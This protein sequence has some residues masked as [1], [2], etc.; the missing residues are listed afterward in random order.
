MISVQEAKELVEQY[1]KKLHPIELPLSKTFGKIL[2]QDV[3]ANTD[4]PA[5]PQSAMDGYAIQ[6]DSIHLD[7][8][9]VVE[10]ESQ[11]GNTEHTSCKAGTAIRIF[12][13]APIPD[14]ADT[15]VIQ[16]HV[17]ASQGK[18][19]IEN[20]EITKGQNIRPQG[21]QVKQGDVA[22]FAGTR[23]NAGTIGFLAG[24]GI[25]A[26]K[27]YPEPKIAL[28]VTGKE[29]VEAGKPLLHGQIYESNSIMLEAALYGKH[30]QLIAK[31]QAD[32]LEEEITEKIAALLPACDILLLTGGVSV[33]DYD[34]V[35]QSL[36]ANE[37]EKVFYKVKQKPGKPLFFGI[38]GQ[39]LV[40]GLPGNPGSV[41]S[42]FYEYVVPAIRKMM[43]MPFNPFEAIQ[44]PL[45]HDYK[46][47]AGL[48]H[49]VKA[50]VENGFAYITKHQESYKLNA[51]P[52]ADCMLVLDE[53][54][55]D[56]AEGDAVWVQHL[57]RCWD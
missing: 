28:I 21:S 50:R 52:Q 25:A 43:G 20:K 5:F 30:L 35:N 10:G 36:M 7:E 12:T 22:A 11:A 31:H 17:R 15:V 16:E 3:P 29:L 55:G 18:I 19:S 47:K 39:T 27:V 37:V 38:K 45:A 49:F 1:S 33:G 41:L 6:L 9:I 13:G 23:L 56:Y 2:A 57:D 42:C 40:F 53:H 48:T 54:K 14:G 46:K 24:L 8:A 51:F 44:L 32:D 4:S 34:F 26:V